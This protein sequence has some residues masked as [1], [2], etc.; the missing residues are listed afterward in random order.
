MKA[1]AVL[2]SCIVLFLNIVPCCWDSCSGEVDEVNA[3]HNPASEEACSPF[4]SCGSCSGFVL[5]Q[6][7]QGFSSISF[8]YRLLDEQEEVIFQS[9]YAIEIWQPPKIG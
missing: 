3:Q 5:Q 6:D 9:D 8:F 7:P 1:L 2:I 4:L